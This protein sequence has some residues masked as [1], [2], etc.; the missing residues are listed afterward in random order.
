MSCSD[1]FTVVVSVALAAFIGTGA[2]GGA[3]VRAFIIEGSGFFQAPG[4]EIGSMAAVDLDDPSQVTPLSRPATDLR[5]GGADQR[6]G[7]GAVVGFENTTNSVRVLSQVADTNT[8]IDSIGWMETGVAGFTF[9][10]DGSVAYATTNV[11]GFGRIVRSDAG[12]GAV[13]S[14]HNILNVTLAGLATVPEGHPTLAAGEIW[15]IGLTG[16]GGVRLYQLDLDTNAVVSSVPVLGVGF[17][18]QFECGLDWS[19]DGTLYAAIQGFRE[20]SPDVFEEI[21]SNLYTID[22]ATGQATNLGVIGGDGTWDAVT[23]VLDDQASAPCIADFAKPFGVLNFFDVA[24][25]IAAYNA[26]DPS[27]DL[28]APF[29]AFNFFDVAAYIGAYNAGCP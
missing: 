6:P 1:R 21:S 24:A 5:F 4:V 11:S 17:N 18:A 20:T 7:T 3:P 26:M 9:S 22:P 25:Y 27:A 23:L 10:N 29:G 8:L 13:L 16:F 14:V 28:A 15:G 12:T 19:G 2:S